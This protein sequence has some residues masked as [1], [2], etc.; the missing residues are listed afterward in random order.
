MIL[1]FN[2]MIINILNQFWNLSIEMAPYL[3]LGFFLAGITSIFISKNTIKKHLSEN[4]KFA[5]FK[6]VIL[7]I[8]LPVCSCG[9]IPI[10]ASLRERGA[11]KSSTAAF[12]ASTP[13]TG[14]DSIIVTFDMMGSV[15]TIFRVIVAFI[16]GIL[17]GLI[18]NI[19]N[20]FRPEEVILKK[21]KN[22]TN[23]RNL[24]DCFYYAFYILPKSLS[25]PLFF[26][27]LIASLISVF[28]QEDFFISHRGSFLEILS[29]LIL[30]IPMYICSTA[31]VPLALS[32]INI[33]ISPGA[34]LIFLII[35]PAT[36][37]LTLTTLWNIIGKKETML[38]VLSISFI[39]IIFGLVLNTFNFSQIISNCESYCDGNH[40]AFDIISVVILYIMIS[41]HYIR[42]LIQIER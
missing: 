18:I 1:V 22:L 15:F 27:I 5:V 25:K 35:G 32:F 10:A 21:E 36:N 20:K 26:G 16:T 7:G 40:N 24:K 37:A 39:A 42:K 38:F 33:G 34:V 23:D 8:P 2:L 41:F 4:S 31:S 6:S 11:S 17:V 12:V 9:V 28:F 29:M 19:F 3:L 30:S 13:Q 14:V